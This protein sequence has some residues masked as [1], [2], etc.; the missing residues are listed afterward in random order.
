MKKTIGIQT[1]LLSIFAVVFIITT[2]LITILNNFIARESLKTRLFNSEIPAIIE[3][4]EAEVEEKLM[5]TVSG[6]SVVAEDPFLQEWILAGEPEETFP[7]ILERLKLNTTRFNTTGS[8]VVVWGTGNYHDY[9]SGNYFMRQIDE[10][11]SWFPAF[12]DSGAASNINAYSN[13]EIFGDVAFINV[14]IDNNGRFLGLVSVKLGI[15]DFVNTVVSK[16]IGEKGSTFMIAPDGIVTLH[17]NKELIGSTNIGT[18]PGYM[19]NFKSISSADSYHFEY[20]KDRNTIYVNT[21]FIPELNWYLITEA[22]QKE[23]FKQMNSALITTILVAL[24]LI[25]IGAAIFFLIIWKSLQPLSKLQQI[26]SEVAS[27]TLGNEI[28]IKYNDEIGLLTNEINKMSQKLSVIVRGVLGSTS[29]VSS[30]SRQLSESADQIAIGA[31]QQSAAVEE[32]SASMEEMISSI[33][34]NADIAKR[35]ETIALKAKLGSEQSSE[36]IDETIRVTNVITEKISVIDEIARQT[37]LLALN[38][39]IEAARAGEA[40]KG[41]AVVASEVR[42]LAE[43]SQT[44]AAEILDLSQNTGEV[45]QKA[46]E[47]LKVLLPDIE[48]TAELIQEISSATKEQAIGADQINIAIERLNGV[49]SQNAAASE[50]LAGTAKSFDE[51][52]NILNNNMNYFNLKK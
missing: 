38:A 33:D 16:T 24:I 39:A 35:T 30:G 51:Q 34:Q 23:L 36:V 43:R 47:M 15:S 10:N 3:T 18:Y 17:K 12:K 52:V 25:A 44:A 28:P 49:V 48:E 14:R 50:E 6:M 40:G 26:T 42:K 31:N 8:N 13:H 37:N 45:S 27:G 1:K 46:V 32:I 4:I 41:F 19:E 2:G 11:D 9:D 22:S 20:R 5:K 7:K 21:K 29:F